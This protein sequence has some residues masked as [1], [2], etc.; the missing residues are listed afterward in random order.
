MDA[1]A[2]CLPGGQDRCPE[3]GVHG[4]KEAKTPAARGRAWM[5]NRLAAIQLPSRQLRELSCA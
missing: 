3:G 4:P 5:W 2:F 1:V